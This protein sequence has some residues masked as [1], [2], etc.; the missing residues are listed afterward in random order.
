MAEPT[1][2]DDVLRALKEKQ[3]QLYQIGGKLAD[4]DKSSQAAKVLGERVQWTSPDGIR[5]L[6]AGATFKELTPGYYDLCVTQQ[7]GLYFE[8]LNLKSDGI[9][10]FPDSPAQVVLEEIQ[11]FWPAEPVFRKFNLS[12]K[13]G[14]MVYGPPGGGKTS[15]FTLMILDIIKRGGIAIKFTLPDMFIAGMKILR[16]I[17][18]DVP[19]VVIMEDIDVLAKSLGE[20]AL[21]N[22]LDG[23]EDISRVVFL[24]STNYPEL[25]GP[26]LINRPSRFDRRF[27]IPHPGDA[28]RKLYIQ[29][30]IAN[31]PAHCAGIDLDRWVAETDGF[32]MA[33]IKELFVA[34]QI[35]GRSF[36]DALE[37]LNLM[38]KDKPSSNQDKKGGGLGVG[39]VKE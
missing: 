6:G 12:F 35:L 39:F 16:S 21:L 11:K 31:D 32:S 18:P 36:E 20:S 8:R 15:L 9:I 4:N 37:T 13:R 27:Q 24:A 17:Q 28:S 2:G 3:N 23:A 30:L 38:M 19:V 26:R 34:T 10:E 5:F 29:S 22:V 7:T 33:H 14:I 25:L 1:Q